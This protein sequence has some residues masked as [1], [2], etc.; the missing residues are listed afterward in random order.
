MPWGR[1]RAKKRRP[2][3]ERGENRAEKKL[4]KKEGREGGSKGR[5]P[6]IDNSPSVRSDRSEDV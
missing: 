4:E 3:A 6:L 5:N 2:V 1:R